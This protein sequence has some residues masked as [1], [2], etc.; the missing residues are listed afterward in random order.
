MPIRI[1]VVKIDITPERKVSL[2]GYFNERLS[3][4]ILDR[5]FLRILAIEGFSK[6]SGSSGR[7]VIIQLD[8]CIIP[9]NFANMVGEKAEELEL[10]NREDVMI[11]ATHTHTA[12][13]LDDFFFTKAETWYREWLFKKIT[14]GLKAIRFRDECLVKLGRLQYENICYNRRWFM[15]DGGVL[16]NPPRGTDELLKPE[17]LIDRELQLLVFSNKNYEPI[18]MLI[19]T[20][21]HTDTV[22]ENAVSAD[23]PGILEQLI[24]DYIGREITLFTTIAPQGNINHFDFKDPS[25]QSGYEI[26]KKI[27]SKYLG[28]IKKC[29]TELSPVELAPVKTIFEEAQIPPREEQLIAPPVLKKSIQT[30]K[31]QENIEELKKA[32]EN[33]TTE[34]LARGH[35][36]ALSLFEYFRELFTRTKPRFYK[37]PLQVITM[38]EVVL[39]CIPGEP[40]VEIGLEL[41]KRIRNRIVMPVALANGY[42]GYIPTMDCFSRGGY[43]TQPH[44][45]NCLSVRAEKII[46]EKIIE[47]YLTQNPL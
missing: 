8:T 5:L 36:T 24:N 10:C 34:D 40:F 35:K 30:V 15:K 25:P 1:S 28:V 29:L 16:T 9:S 42:F 14:E 45:W 3:E 11:Y 21:N 44:P 20:S 26:T 43:E 7:T 2:L 46:T 27:A 33:L 32:I 6:N 22:G 4:K 37:V 31:I 47:M 41:K 19:N 17:G 18:C 38:G 12:P 23:W 13:A 39:V